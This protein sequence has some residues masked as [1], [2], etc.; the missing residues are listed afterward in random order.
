[1]QVNSRTYKSN[2]LKINNMGNPSIRFGEYTPTDRKATKECKYIPPPIPQGNCSYYESRFTNFMKR[3]S[4]CL[5]EPP[6][7]YYGPLSE[8][9]EI[10]AMNKLYIRLST[11]PTHLAFTG[12]TDGQRAIKK[13]EEERMRKDMNSPYKYERAEKTLVPRPEESYG[14]KYCELFTNEL[15]PKLTI[16]GKKWLKQVKIDLQKLMEQGIV[17]KYYVSELSKNYNIENKLTND[18]GEVIKVNIK[19]FYTN[20]ELNNTR[21]QSFAFA[22]HPDAYNPTVM[23][24]LPAQDLI[25]IMFTPDFKEWLD[26]ETWKQVWTMAKNMNYG[27][28]TEST[29]Q[30]LKKDTY[31]I[32]ENGAK[33]LKTYWDEIF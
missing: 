16:D 2:S 33:E 5:H 17:N 1:V 30:K 4:D 28:I 21:F 10:S 19:K 11:L 3:H 13:A 8:M 7:Y 23:S 18:E 26:S 31:E 24:K 12:Q 9:G 29:W 14:Y 27:T 6:V 20:I 15:M 32:I 22:T 25:R